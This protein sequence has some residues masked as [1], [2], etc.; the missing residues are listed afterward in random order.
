MLR[1]SIPFLPCVGSLYFCHAFMHTIPTP[2]SI[3]TQYHVRGG[4][5]CLK[6]LS[7][8]SAAIFSESGFACILWDRCAM[9][10]VFL[11]G[12]LV[13]YIVSCFK[14]VDCFSIQPQVISY[15]FLSS[16][17]KVVGLLPASAFLGIFMIPKLSKWIFFLLFYI[18][19]D[20]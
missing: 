8:Q 5:R 1:L 7:Y 10:K 12:R 17:T 2:T 11:A 19:S 16:C 4:C 13:Q 15:Y 18:D 14:C 9:L 20:E 6:F 3:V